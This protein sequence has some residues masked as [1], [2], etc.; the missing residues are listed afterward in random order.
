MKRMT[1]VIVAML[2]GTIGCVGSIDDSRDGIGATDE[3]LRGDP[4]QM[5]AWVDK[6]S[7][8]YELYVTKCNPLPDVKNYVAM[9]ACED[10]GTNINAVQVKVLDAAGH[11]VDDIHADRPGGGCIHLQ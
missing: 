6:T 11:V 10:N 2:A 8:P 9:E 7:V 3:Q 5:N 1:I 4:S